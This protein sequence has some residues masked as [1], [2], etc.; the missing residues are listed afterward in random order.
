MAHMDAV[1]DDRAFT[2]LRLAV[3]PAAVAHP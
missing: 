1:A 3:D 2:H